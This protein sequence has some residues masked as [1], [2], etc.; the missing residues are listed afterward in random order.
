MACALSAGYTTDCKDNA[1]GARE[2]KIIEFANV[3]PEDITVTANVV[4]A[5]TNATAKRWWSYR[6]ARETAAG[7]A[8][9]TSNAQNGTVYWAH[10]VTMALNKMQTT[11]RTEV[12]ALARNIV[13]IAVQDQNGKYWLYGR[14]NGME[15]SGGESGTGTAMGDRNGYSI[16]FTGNEPEEAIEI[17]QDTWDSL[18]T[19]GA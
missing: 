3:A 5:I 16:T 8:T 2:L 1:G 6:P 4:T 17:D 14:F 12:M 18:E 10:E 13:L 9:I 15:V 19:P 11:L 7:K